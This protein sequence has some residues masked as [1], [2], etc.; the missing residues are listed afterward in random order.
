MT[1]NA[2]QRAF[3]ISTLTVSL[4][5]IGA[6]ALAQ[7]QTP[8]AQPQQ[9]APPSGAWRKVGDPPAPVQTS[10]D[11]AVPVQTQPQTPPQTQDPSQPVDRTDAYGQPLP[12]TGQDAPPIPQDFPPPPQQNGVVMAPPQN[13][14]PQGQNRPAYGVPAQVTLPQGTYLTVRI[15]QMLSSDHSQPGQTFTATLM[16]P[17]VANGIVVAHRGQLVFGIVSE[18]QKQKTDKPSR[19][20]VQLTGL[21]LADA[22]QAKINTVMAQ[23]Q[24][25]KTPNGIQAG[26]V[27]G[28][29]ALGAGVGAAV[30][31]GTGAAVGAG[32]GFIVGLAGVLLTRNHPTVIY[33]ETLLTFQTVGATTFDTSHNPQAFH[34]VGPADYGGPGARMTQLQPRPPSGPGGYPA[35]YGGA[36]YGGAYAAPYGYYPPYPYYYPYY[37][38]YGGYGVVVGGRWGGWGRWR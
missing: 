22:S 20:G 16:E 33:P 18:V 24:G 6:L 8:P 3:R 9:Q 13:G 10:P 2:K 4:V 12:P 37:P 21:T 32:A 29:T 27:A 31:W 5:A 19:L 25:G 11:P 34:Y 17:V 35:P 15:N 28:T 38:F 30:G 14:A 36:Y 26:T 23:S 1:R 7:D